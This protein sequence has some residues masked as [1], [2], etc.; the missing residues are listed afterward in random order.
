MSTLRGIAF[1]VIGLASVS[2]VQ[3]SLHPRLAPVT[4]PI[5]RAGV[6]HV[7]TGTWTRNASLA[8][9]TGP[10]IIYNNTCAGV[11]FSPM[12]NTESYQH[13]SRIPSPSGPWSPSVFYGWPRHDEAPGCQPSYTVD[14]F[15]VAYCTNTTGSVDWTYEFAS[16]Y[17]LCGTG[18]MIPDYTIVVTGMPGS[19]SNGSQNCW[20]VDL[21]ISGIPGGGIV[22]SA[23]GDGTYIGPSTAEQFGF[24][25]TQ[26]LPFTTNTGPII[27]GDY[28]F[29]GGSVTGP[30]TPC[31]GTDGTIW[32]DWYNPSEGGTGMASKTSSAWRRLRARSALP[33]APAATR[34]AAH[35]T[36]TSG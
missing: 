5:R 21:D 31:T 11:Y 3:Q 10:D 2:F 35:R 30:L 33:R 28:T 20:I 22:F 1:F 17:T 34:S 23:D 18:D 32:D 16:S 36:R 7:A 25:M 24:S 13:R 4:A 9:V 26:S 14:G 29:L 6:Y 19:R 12:A 27:A 8:N 15:Q